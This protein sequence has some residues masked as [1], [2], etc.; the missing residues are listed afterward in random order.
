MSL[1][2]GNIESRTPFILLFYFPEILDENKDWHWHDG[3]GEAGRGAGSNPKES[4]TNGARI[5]PR[6]Q[7]S[8]ADSYLL[9]PLPL[10]A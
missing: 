2:K 1:Q 5:A 4:Q 8:S 9:L 3:V 7:A 10:N 6:L